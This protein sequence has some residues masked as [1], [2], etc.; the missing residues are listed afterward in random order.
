MRF[1][2]TAIKPKQSIRQ[3]S[4]EKTLIKEKMRVLDD[5]DICSRYDESMK[6]HLERAIREHPDKDPQEVLDSY[7]RPMIQEKVNSWV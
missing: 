1:R 3:S 2:E 7:C 5:F 4:T 6:K